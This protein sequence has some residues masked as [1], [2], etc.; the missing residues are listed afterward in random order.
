[1]LF[2]VMCKPCTVTFFLYISE[3]TPSG[4]LNT[5]PYSQIWI[6]LPASLLS[7]LGLT[8]NSEKEIRVKAL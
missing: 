8:G 1:M 7:L 5:P 3:N 2:I 4:C 6:S